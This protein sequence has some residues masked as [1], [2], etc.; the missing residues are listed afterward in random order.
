MK[1]IVLLMY[2]TGNQLFREFDTEQ[3][4]MQYVQKRSGQV[5][6]AA[7]IVSGNSQQVMAEGVLL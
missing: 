4:A 1:Y 5:V 2:W 6:Q 3:E 7:W